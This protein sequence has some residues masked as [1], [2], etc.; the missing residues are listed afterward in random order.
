M[1][2]TT[3]S[4]QV[5]QW[6]AQARAGDSRA[7]GRLL[8]FCGDEIRRCSR[9]R[10][11]GGINC[12]L[13]AKFDFGD[14]VQESYLEAQHDF[15]R[16]QGNTA[17]EIA[18]WFLQIFGHTMNDMRRRFRRKKRSCRREIALCE[19]I[20][21][22][23]ATAAGLMPLEEVVKSEELQRGNLA[24]LMLPLNY[25]LV[26]YFRIGHKMSFQEIADS[27]SCT[28]E[29]ALKLYGR[30]LDKLRGILAEPKAITEFKR[31]LDFQR[32]RRCSYEKICKF[33]DHY[34]KTA[35]IQTTE[36]AGASS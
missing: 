23:H 1:D 5:E 33:A 26:L 28:V 16:F 35:K 3:T 22:E 12:R 7:L 24:L 6:L 18:G 36:A 17:P 19:E 34:A 32:T 2:R 15:P 25:Y 8:L 4:E 30:A 21:I 31:Q 27:Q 11:L 9:R 10:H 29:A 13:R 14:I 20:A